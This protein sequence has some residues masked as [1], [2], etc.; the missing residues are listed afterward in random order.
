MR[1]VLAFGGSIITRGFDSPLDFISLPEPLIVNCTGLGAKRLFRDDELTPVKGQLTVLVP[2]PDVNYSVGGMIP[3]SS[4]IVLGHVRQHGVSSLSV[5]DA[6]QIR[7]V[8]SAIRTFSTMRPPD[9]RVGLTP[10]RPLTGGPPVE[11]FL[12]LES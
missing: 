7:V 8:E 5:D 12:R 1:D 4:G 10:F 6:E 2:Q 3:R 9:P 11:S